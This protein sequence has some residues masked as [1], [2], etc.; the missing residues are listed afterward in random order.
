MRAVRLVRW[1]FA[2]TA[3]VLVCGGYAWWRHSTD[4]I[5]DAVSAEGT[6][7]DLVRSSSRS[8]ERGTYRP[9]VRFRTQAGEEVEFVSNWSSYP[10]PYRRG[11]AVEVLYS[12]SDARQ[13]RTKRFFAL[14]GGP[15]IT[16]L[17]GLAFTIV[18]VALFFIPTGRATENG[19]DLGGASPPSSL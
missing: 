1:I 16:G 11:D 3:V 15:M 5:R 10:P 12:P 13:A 2:V 8:S 19:R 4:F 17:L 14:W 6:V 18:A 9:V 7:I